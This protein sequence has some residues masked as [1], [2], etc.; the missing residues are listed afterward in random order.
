MLQTPDSEPLLA[1]YLTF[2]SQI[3]VNFG[4][5]FSSFTLR[6]RFNAVEEDLL[7]FLFSEGPYKASE[8]IF[9]F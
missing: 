2:L 1:F 8:F 9:N 7:L 6:S 3:N 5:S 4:A